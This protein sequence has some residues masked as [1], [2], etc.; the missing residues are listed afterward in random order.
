LIRIGGDAVQRPYTPETLADRW[1]CSSEKVRQMFHR[2]ELPGFRLGKLIRIPAVE[3]ERFE[4]E[5]TLQVQV[6]TSSNIA[7]SSHSQLDA[8][9]I[10]ADIRLARMTRA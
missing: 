3:V 8:G 10:A 7:E 2:G 9:R 5:Q 4:C 6:T 1:G